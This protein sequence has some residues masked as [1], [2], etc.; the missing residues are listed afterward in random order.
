MCWF[1]S[2]A[3]TLAHNNQVGP[4]LALD[5]LGDFLGLLTIPLHL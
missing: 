5:I 3:L 4:L 1:P 2:Q